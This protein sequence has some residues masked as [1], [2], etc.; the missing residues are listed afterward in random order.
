M[1]LKPALCL[2]VAL[3]LCLTAGLAALGAALRPADD[4]YVAAPALTQVCFYEELET[5]PPG[6]LVNTPTGQPV[7][8][9]TGRQLRE[10]PVIAALR[11]TGRC[12]TP[13]TS[14]LTEATVTRVFAGELKAGDVVFVMDWAIVVG[15]NDLRSQSGW[16]PMRPGGEYLL[17][18]AP[19]PA[20][21]QM[22]EEMTR[23]Y[24]PEW[25]VFG[26]YPLQPGETTRLLAGENPY[27]PIDA[28]SL[29]AVFFSRS[30]QA[31][32]RAYRQQIWQALGVA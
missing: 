19:F 25:G 29:D 20:T 12:L 17:F 13:G 4:R 2:L 30:A 15:P 10:C 1:R 9:P 11:P 23:C 14:L 7:P 5:L 22:P 18:M 28:T 32:Y 6:Q 16:L 3:P 8:P 21:P 27:S 31:S 24:A 26:K